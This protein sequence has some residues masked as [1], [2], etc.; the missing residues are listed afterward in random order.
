MFYFFYSRRF[1][2]SVSGFCGSVVVII[3]VCAVI[4]SRGFFIRDFLILGFLVEEVEVVAVV[5]VVGVAVVV[6]V[7]IVGFSGFIL[8]IRVIII[9]VDELVWVAR[10]CRGFV[11]VRKGGKRDLR[12]EIA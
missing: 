12:W 2:F 7:V 5:V 6:V 3:S 1:Y 11:R 4:V 9:G 8:Y 10:S